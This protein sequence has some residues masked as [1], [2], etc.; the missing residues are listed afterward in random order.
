MQLIGRFTRRAISK[1]VET[2]I[3]VSRGNVALAKWKG[4]KI[5]QNCRIYIR[6]FGTE[7][8]LIAIGDRVTITQGCSLIT[9]DGSTWLILDEDGR[10]Y[11][12]YAPI[13]ISND[14]FIGVNSIIMPGVTIG[15][16][17]VIGAGSVV[18]KDVPGNS[19]VAGNPA[20]L[21]C[22]FDTLEGKIRARYANDRELDGCASYRERAARAMEIERARNGRSSDEVVATTVNE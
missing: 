6:D 19:V 3:A 14:V 18:T 13:T 2:L 22:S 16:R 1:L 7:P 21:I 10:R 11:Q 4:V 12:H 9:H 17:V 8:F 5:G 20:R 15:S